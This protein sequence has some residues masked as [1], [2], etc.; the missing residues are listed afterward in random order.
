MRVKIM[1][2]CSAALEENNGPPENDP[3][4]ENNKTGNAFVIGAKSLE[5]Q[6]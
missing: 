3:Y 4:T 5:L 2:F 6:K 1:I